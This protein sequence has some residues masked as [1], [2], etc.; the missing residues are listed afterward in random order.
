M[1]RAPAINVKGGA[2]VSGRE[3][4]RGTEVGGVGRGK[5]SQGVPW[6]L[7]KGQRER[8]HEKTEHTPNGVW[9]CIHYLVGVWGCNRCCWVSVFLGAEVGKFPAKLVK[10]ARQN[11]RGVVVS[12]GKSAIWPH[13]GR[14][15]R[16]WL[17]SWL[18]RVFLS[19]SKLEVLPVA[20]ASPGL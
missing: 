11:E 4:G 18:L 7:V 12:Q 6:S 1:K 10:P 16:L 13:G 9:G 2:S 17:L 14:E 3:E 19:P 8:S 15:Q 5:T 20:P